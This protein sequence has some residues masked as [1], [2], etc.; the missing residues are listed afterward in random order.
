MD[1]VPKLIFI[2]PYRD[3]EQQRNFFT[4]QMKTILADYDPK[5]YKIYFSHQRDNRAFNRGAMKNI[6]FLAM[7]EKYPHHYRNITFVFNDIDTMPFSKNFLNYQTSPGNVKHFYGY[8]YALGGI[9]SI[10]GQDFE[11]VNGFPN[12]WAWGFEDNELNRRVKEAGLTIDRSQFYPIMDKNI[13]QLKDG[14][15]RLVNRKEFDRYLQ[16]TNEGISSIRNLYYDL[17]ESGEFIQIHRFLTEYEENK[18]YTKVHDLR[19]GSRPFMPGIETTP[20]RRRANATMK[21]AL[22]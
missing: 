10:C 19:N 2:V 13:L 14:L 5:D 4:S 16:R 20:N 15:T 11:R 6:G 1:S 17:D 21:M 18:Q 3:R 7:K 12:Y 22:N 8:E 9:V